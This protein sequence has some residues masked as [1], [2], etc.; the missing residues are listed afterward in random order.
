MRQVQRSLVGL[1]ARVAEKHLAGE[2]SFGQGL[3]Q[4]D[5]PF[6]EVKVGGVVQ[7]R[8]LCDDGLRKPLV[9]VAEHAYRDSR[10]HVEVA[11]TIRI[12]Q[13]AAFAARHDDGRPAVVV[14]Q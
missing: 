1:G 12:R 11:A 6:D 5:L 2:G 3:G 8:R 10:R 7:A 4:S 13:L 9:A 14:H